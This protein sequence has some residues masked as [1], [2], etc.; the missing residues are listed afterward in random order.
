MAFQRVVVYG[1]GAT[2]SYLGARLCSVI[3]VTL[4]ARQEH[5]EAVKGRGLFVGGKADI[6]VPPGR[7][8]AATGVSALSAGCLVLVTVK[9]TGAAE[10]GR[11]LARLARPDSAFVLAQNG[12]AG[13]ELFLAGAGRQLTVVRAIA[14]C[15]VDFREAGKVEYWGGGL[16][17]EPGPLGA[18]LV[19]L[20][21][22]AGV[23]AEESP[24]FEKALW[25]K[26]AANCVINPITA[27]LEVRNS[28]A[29][30]PELAGLR[31]AIVAEVAALAAAEGH[32]LPEDLGQRIEDGLES[33]GNRSSML[34]D[35]LLGRPTEVEYLCGFVER[36]SA[37]LKLSAPVNA[38][39]AAL[40]RAKSASRDPDTGASGGPGN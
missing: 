7:I 23:E 24:D 30:A 33:G 37:E 27:L 9:L 5:V 6:F 31:R 11:D 8:Q 26:L 39:L 32:P 16:S 18:E 2:G 36:R 13:R 4:I 29:M 22:R 20:F 15:G 3:P 1:A 35:I 38:A 34:Q 10:A 25:K 28:G 19:E 12:L 17:F 40:V 21:R 14:S